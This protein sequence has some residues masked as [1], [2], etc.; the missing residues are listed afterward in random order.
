MTP[1]TTGFNNNIIMQHGKAIT[2][3]TMPPWES[4]HKAF[5]RVVNKQQE[6]IMPLLLHKENLHVMIKS[7]LTQRHSQENF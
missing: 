5:H 6:H 3:E 2:T 7:F 1:Y 4:T